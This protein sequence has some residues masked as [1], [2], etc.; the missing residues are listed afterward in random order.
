VSGAAV[1]FEVRQ[2]R[3]GRGLRPAPEAPVTPDY[4]AVG[5]LFWGFDLKPR[6]WPAIFFQQS[7]MLS[8]LSMAQALISARLLPRVQK[9]KCL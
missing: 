2:R 3:A 6:Q 8:H 4:T 9:Q 7:G 1:V 5:G